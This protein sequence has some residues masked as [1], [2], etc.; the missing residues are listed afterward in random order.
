MTNENENVPEASNTPEKPVYTVEFAPG[1]FDGFEGTQEELQ[2]LIAMIHAKVADGSII[3]EAR[4][5]DDE[6]SEEVVEEILQR[7]EAANN[8]TL[9]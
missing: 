6:E 7:I 1:C 8:R 4:L 2:E 5:L 3:T 9:Q